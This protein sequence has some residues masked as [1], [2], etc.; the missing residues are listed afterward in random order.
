VFFYHNAKVAARLIEQN[1]GKMPAWASNMLALP[2][3]DEFTL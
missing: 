3:A 1:A 2:A